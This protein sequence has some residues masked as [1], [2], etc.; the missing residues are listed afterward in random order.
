M[1][2]CSIHEGE[3][4]RKLRLILGLKQNRMAFIL[5]KNWN[6]QKISYWEGRHKI[7]ISTLNEI[8]H[9]LQVPVWIFQIPENIF[10]G[11]VLQI[12]KPII[13]DDYFYMQKIVELYERLLQS[14]REKYALFETVKWVQCAT[15][16]S[17]SKESTNQS[18][19]F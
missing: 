18:F 4:V 12:Q 17:E 9:V 11:I 10:N 13:L 8:S 3:N 14:E 15:S 5:G 7:K 19:D 6:Q 1:T 2:N 16:S